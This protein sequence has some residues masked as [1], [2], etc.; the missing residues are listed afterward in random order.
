MLDLKYLTRWRLFDL[1]KGC[2]VYG[3]YRVPLTAVGI[4]LAQCLDQNSRGRGVVSGVLSAAFKHQ[5]VENSSALLSFKRR[6]LGV[7]LNP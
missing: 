7:A 2:T 6:R 5:V 1:M 3:D 4:L